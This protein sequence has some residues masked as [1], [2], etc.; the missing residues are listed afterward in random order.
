MPLINERDRQK[1]KERFDK[2]LSQ[3]VTIVFFTQKELPLVIPGRECPYCKE[4]RQ[5]LEEVSSLS[6]KIRLSV[7]DFMVDTAQVQQCGIDTIPAAVLLG[8]NAG[9][10][11]YFGIPSGASPPAMNSL[12]CSRTS[13]TSPRGPESWLRRPRTNWPKSKRTPTSRCLLPPP[14]HIA[15]VWPGWP[16]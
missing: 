10:V 1:I 11:R 15:P 13:L 6:G 3:E 2:E 14:D 9:R 16:T 5:L 8:C 7:H 12:P 4:T